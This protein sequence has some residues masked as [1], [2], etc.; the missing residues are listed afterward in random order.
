MVA[1]S[2]PIKDPEIVP[3]TTFTGMNHLTVQIKRRKLL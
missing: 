1:T 2:K 3:R